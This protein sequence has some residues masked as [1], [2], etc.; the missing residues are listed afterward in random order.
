MNAILKWRL[1]ALMLELYRSGGEGRG[2]LTPVIYAI[3]ESLRISLL[4]EMLRLFLL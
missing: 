3:F 2:T 4:G 1:D